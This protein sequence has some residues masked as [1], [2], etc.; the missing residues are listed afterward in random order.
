[1]VQA[2][3]HNRINVTWFIGFCEA[4]LVI[5]SIAFVS[6]TPRLGWILP[7]SDEGKCE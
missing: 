7:G 5:I 2:N 3:A 1:V 4:W 6:L